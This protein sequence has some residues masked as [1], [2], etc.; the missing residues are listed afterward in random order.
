MNEEQKP[1]INHYKLEKE[2]VKKLIKNCTSIDWEA[3]ASK[4]DDIIDEFL[5]DLNFVVLADA[6]KSIDRYG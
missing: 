1:I 6:Y 3:N 2:C 4:S 5:R